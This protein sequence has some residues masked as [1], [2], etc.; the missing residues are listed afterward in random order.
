M[1]SR[2]LHWI[3]RIVPAIILLQTLFFKFSAAPESVFIFSSL[4]LEPYGRIGTGVVEL[5]ASV[6][7]L[8]PRTTWMGALLSLGVI[9]GAILSHLFFLGL[10]IMEDGGYLFILAIIVFVCS[11]ILLWIDRKKVPLLSKL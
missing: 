4:N 2:I 3:I 8:V 10:E 5:I 11:A 9:S 7:M 6:L 1:R